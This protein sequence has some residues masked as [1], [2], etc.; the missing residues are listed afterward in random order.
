K[1]TGLVRLTEVNTGK[2]IRRISGE[3]NTAASAIAYAPD[4]KTLAFSY[5][6]QIYMHEAETG[7]ELHKI[8]VPLAV[9]ALAFAPDGRTL[10]AKAQDRSIYL[11]ETATGNRKHRLGEDQTGQRL[12]AAIL[13]FASGD[14]AALAFSP[15]GRTVATGDGNTLRLWD[16]TT[17][18]EA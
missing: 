13:R 12:N 2:E 5:S 8:G 1:T 11:L 15:D 3:Q 17:G 16:V 10:A 4:G 14:L 18:K 7:K 9:T 6:N